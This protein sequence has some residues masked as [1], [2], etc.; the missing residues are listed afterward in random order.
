M[1]QDPTFTIKN[2]TSNQYNKEMLVRKNAAEE[3]Y[4]HVHNEESETYTRSPLIKPN[5]KKFTERKLFSQCSNLRKMNK[6]N[7][8]S[9]KNCA[10][11]H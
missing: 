11:N 8:G 1:V 6:F 9:S 4:I 2:K 5:Q 7:V 3:I 10:K